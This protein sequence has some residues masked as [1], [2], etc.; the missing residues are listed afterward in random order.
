VKPRSQPVLPCTVDDVSGSRV[1]DPVGLKDAAVSA[2]V[3]P[4]P[5]A[6]S[7]K[8]AQ[9]GVSAATATVM[10]LDSSTR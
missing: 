1:G 2:A 9:G 6:S 3:L 5:F 10:S 4:E 7:L 8:D